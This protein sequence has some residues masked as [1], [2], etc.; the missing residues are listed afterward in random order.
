MLLV[1]FKPKVALEDKSERFLPKN[2]FATY[3][4][5]SYQDSYV[6]GLYVGKNFNEF[7]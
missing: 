2:L 7:C 6:L 1:F 4:N 3:Q 5:L